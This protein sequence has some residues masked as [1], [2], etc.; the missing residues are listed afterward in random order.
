MSRRWLPI[1]CLSA[2]SLLA[3]QGAGAQDLKS[4]PARDEPLPGSFQA[5]NINGEFK[6]RHHCLV[7]QF[8][9]NPAVLVFV[10]QQGTEIDPEV[11]KLI[12]ALDETC[13]AHYAEFGLS[14]AAIFL[15]PGARSSVTVGV[16]GKDT[17]L[18]QEAVIRE[19]LVVTMRKEIEDADN[20]K[21]IWAIYPAEALPARYNLA[22]KAEVTVIVYYRHHVY[23][24][25]GFADGQ[26]KDA[27]VA[28]VRQAID[29]MLERIKKGPGGAKKDD[30]G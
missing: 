2:V 17:D 21:V 14:A 22:A 9:A 11:K 18:V 28:K 20:K 6:E 1:V 25:F 7:T 19:K 26:L 4:G 12:K 5:L 13:Q 23:Q 10:R 24:T 30:K 16:G 27:G 15:T 29:D 8:R 3:I